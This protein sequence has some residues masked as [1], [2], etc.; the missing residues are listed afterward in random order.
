M[1]TKTDS[2]PL[3]GYVDSDFANDVNDRKSVGGFIFKV[4][5]NT[6]MWKPK[7]QTVVALSSAEAEYIA[8]A[9]CC[10]ECLFLLKLLNELISVTI[11]PV[12]INEDNQ[13][14][15]KMASTLETKS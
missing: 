10:A 4:Y 3:V 15:I 13:S 5:G 11:T 8:L 9:L 14:C 2:E 7:K 6:I 1:Y 12:T